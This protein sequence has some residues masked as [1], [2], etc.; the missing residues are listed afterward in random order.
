MVGGEE[1]HVQSNERTADQRKSLQIKG[2]LLYNSSVHPIRTV[3]TTVFTLPT[4]LFPQSHCAHCTMHTMG[5]YNATDVTCTPNLSCI[6]IQFR[7]MCGL[8]LW[9]LLLRVR[10]HETAARV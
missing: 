7:P 5:L 1:A 4:V 3:S 2:S 8:T 6:F 9:L 10:G